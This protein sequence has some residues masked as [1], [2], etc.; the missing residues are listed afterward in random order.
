[1]TDREVSPLVVIDDRDSKVLGLITEDDIVR[2]VCVNDYVSTNIVKNADII[3]SPLI[4]NKSNSS[5]KDATDLL[6][7]KKIRHLLV[8]DKEDANKPVGLVT[9]MDFTRYMDSRHE[10]NENNAISRIFEYYRDYYT[11]G[12]K[13]PPTQHPS[14]LPFLDQI[15]T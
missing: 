1:M 9:T 10:D 14:H 5:P 6:I 4:I 3:S 7:E 13:I 8:V 11:A 12:L 2:N 15:H